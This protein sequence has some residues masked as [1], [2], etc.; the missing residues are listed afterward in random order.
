[1]TLI[2]TRLR[3]DHIYTAKTANKAPRIVP[4]EPS[5]NRNFAPAVTTLVVEAELVPSDC[6]LDSESEIESDFEPEPELEPDFE[7][8]REPVDFDSDPEADPEPE[9]EPE[10]ASEPEAAG[11]PDATSLLK[12]STVFQV[13]PSL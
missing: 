10:L 2:S 5:S 11:R 1:M 4:A 9:P 7:P 3:N 12:A 13:L 6:E 8:V